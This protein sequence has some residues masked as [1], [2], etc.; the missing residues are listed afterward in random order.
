MQF[1]ALIPN[2]LFILVLSRAILIKTAKYKDNFNCFVC[3]ATDTKKQFSFL[4]ERKSLFKTHA[5]FF[6]HIYDGYN[7]GKKISK[8]CIYG[9]LMS[10]EDTPSDDYYTYTCS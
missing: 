3:F 1:F 9:K 7:Y 8:T 10:L 6:W 2:I 5:Y 4:N